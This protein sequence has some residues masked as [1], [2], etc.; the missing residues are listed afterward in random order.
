MTILVILV[1]VHIV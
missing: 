1:N